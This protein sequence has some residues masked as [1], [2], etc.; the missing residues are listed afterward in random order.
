MRHEIDLAGDDWRLSGIRPGQGEKEGFEG[1]DFWDRGWLTAAVPGDVHSALLANGAIDD[2]Y[3]GMNSQKQLWIPEMEWWYRKSLVVP[4][5]W[6]GKTIRLL[7]SGVDYDAT[8]WFNGVRIGRHEG[9]FS[10]FEFDVTRLA[11][12]DESNTLAV[13]LSPP[14]R[15]RM[16]I[17]GRKCGLG[18]GIDYAPALT[19][20]GIWD[21]VRLVA[22]GNIYI[23]DIQLYPRLT[24]DHAVVEVDVD[25]RSTSQI[26]PENLDLSVAIQGQNFD[27]AVHQKAT[28]VAL[29]KRSSKARLSIE[30][31]KPRRWWPH[32]L[33]RANLY[34]ASVELR[35][36]GEVCDS[37]ESTFGLRTIERVSNDEAPAD[38]PPWVFMINGVRHFIKG[39]NWTTID[40]LPGRMTE[41]RYSKL[42]R[43]AREANINMLRNHG[44]HIR[45]KECFYDLCDREG[46]LVWQEFAFANTDYPSDERFLKAVEKEARSI[47]KDIS[48]HP[49]VA[50]FTPG[51]EF[52]YQRN[53]RLMRRLEKVCKQEAP[54]CEFAYTDENY[55]K[56]NKS[57]DYHNWQV[58]WGHKLEPGNQV[59][60]NPPDWTYYSKDESLFTSEFGIQAIPAEASLRRFIPEPELWPP[61]KTWAHHFG[62]LDRIKHYASMSAPKR[63]LDSLE[64]LIEASQ[65]SQAEGLRYAIEHYRRRKYRTGGC[66]FWQFNEPW[67]AIVWSIVDWYGEPKLAYSYVKRAYAPLLVSAAYEKIS[68]QRDDLFEARIWIINDLQEEPEDCR[69][70]IRMGDEKGNVL[71]DRELEHI[72]VER[73]SSFEVERMAHKLEDAEGKTFHLELELEDND[74][75]SLCRNEYV[76]AL[77]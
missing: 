44:W 1:K 68:W 42:L 52:S 77:E 47:A 23:A 16:R 5:A 30:I 10:S 48:H 32:S 66:M 39:A 65:L 20:S 74:R 53:L 71:Y 59:T 7:F 41:E 56:G 67:P 22:T 46:I 49:C 57:G 73:D 34:R 21:R 25:L 43:L 29:R 76:F 40:L 2:P 14:P 3:F 9:M 58:W 38:S 45:E 18:Y 12:P 17:G 36:N 75:K 64:G 63:N 61:G 26:L 33:G 11:A 6:K 13:K 55:V 27:S 28:R 8:F 50:I 69:L 35:R 60:P 37:I 72:R 15:N 19:T 70:L 4:S 62:V 54:C 51:N 31:E 24:D